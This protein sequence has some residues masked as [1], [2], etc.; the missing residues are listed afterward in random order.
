MF[1]NG[2][3]VF[4]RVKRP[5]PALHGADVMWEWYPQETALIRQILDLSSWDREIWIQGPAGTM[6]RYR[7]L[8]DTVIVVQGEN[9]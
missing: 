7:I 8:S 9:F 4:V 5:H 1:W 3:E 6:Q 2:D